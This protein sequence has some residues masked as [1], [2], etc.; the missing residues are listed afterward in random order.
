MVPTE[1]EDQSGIYEEGFCSARRSNLEVALVGVAAGIDTGHHAASDKGGDDRAGGPVLMTY[2]EDVLSRK[3]VSA[4]IIR[5]RG[6]TSG[7]DQASTQAVEAAARM[8]LEAKNPCMYAGP[9]AWTAARARNA[10]SLR[11][12]WAFRQCEC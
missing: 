2:P 8:L 11:S 7:V 10:L 12:C 3:D 1:F 5:K 4:T 6:L 9:E